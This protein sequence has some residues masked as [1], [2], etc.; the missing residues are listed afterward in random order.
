MKNLVIIHI[1][2]GIF[3]S[4]RKC[5]QARL[6]LSFLYMRMNLNFD[7]CC[8]CLPSTEITRCETPHHLFVVMGSNQ[9]QQHSL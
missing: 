3:L 8:L 2:S 1:V 6:A 9:D 4:L 7:S 5:L